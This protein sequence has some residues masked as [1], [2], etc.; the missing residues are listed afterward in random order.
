MGRGKTTSHKR[1]G[2]C[3]ID[4]DFARAQYFTNFRGTAGDRGRVVV[5][6]DLGSR[7]VVIDR[8]FT[9]IFCLC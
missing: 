7:L 6:Y 9:S 4:L 1:L 2:F 3:R 5:G 8:V